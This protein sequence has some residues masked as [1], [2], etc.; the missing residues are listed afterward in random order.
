MGRTFDAV[1][2]LPHILNEIKRYFVNNGNK[3]TRAV[4]GISGGKDS[5][6]AAAL[7][8]RALG[9]DRVVGVMMPEGTQ[10]DIHDSQEVCDIL[11]IEAYTI[12]IDNTVQALYSGLIPVRAQS[13]I[14]GP[15]PAIVTTNTPARVRM[16]TLYAVAGIVGG[17]VI[18][19]GNASEMYVGYTTKYGDMAGDFSIFKD[20]Y[21]R[22]ILAL[23]NILE[24]LP[25]HLVHKAPGD[26]MTGKTDEDN[27]GFTYEVLD[28]YLL[29]NETPSYEVLRLIEERHERNLHKMH[30]LNIP[31][32]RART[33]KWENNTNRHGG[34]FEA[35]HEDAPFLD[36]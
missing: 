23:G 19:T 7:L 8:V 1:A 31:Y 16:A 20:Y 30:M 2:E 9:K 35:L 21:V 25:P 22:E 6:I 14:D 12:N 26:G 18:H 34:C 32:I 11:G 10:K 28:A 24:E 13:E 36:F 15:L 17:R 29:D 33:R 27:F 3:N 5:T 4:I